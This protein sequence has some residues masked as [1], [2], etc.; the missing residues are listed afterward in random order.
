MTTFFSFWALIF[1]TVD[2]TKTYLQNNEIKFECK[3]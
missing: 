3:Q 1:V 2:D